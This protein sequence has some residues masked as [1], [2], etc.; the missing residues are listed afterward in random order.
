[1][2]RKAK[3]SQVFQK[4]LRFGN[5]RR[6]ANRENMLNF[7]FDNTVIEKYTTVAR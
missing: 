6:P 4:C 7:L 3:G 2:L 5:P 1:M